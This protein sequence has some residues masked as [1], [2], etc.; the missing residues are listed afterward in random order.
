MDIA[1]YSISLKVIAYSSTSVCRTVAF[2]RYTHEEYVLESNDYYCQ[3]ISNS[4]LGNLMASR[5]Q[6]I[7]D[8]II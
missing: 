8:E 3:I 4:S 5:Y 6:D 1:V 7:Q 2:N